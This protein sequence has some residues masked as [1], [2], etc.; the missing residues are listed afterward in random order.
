MV[1]DEL[2]AQGWRMR[3]FRFGARMGVWRRRYILW[4]AAPL[5]QLRTGQ[6]GFFP[7]LGLVGEVFGWWM[8]MWDVRVER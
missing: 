3:G 6:N 7:L 4:D 1:V 2:K 5:C 8:R